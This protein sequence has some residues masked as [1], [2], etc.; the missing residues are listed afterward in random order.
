MAG[1]A[2][3]QTTQPSVY[4]TSAGAYNTAVQN[5]AS[6]AAFGQQVQGYMNPYTQNV[7]NNSL[8]DLERSR[9]MTMNNIGAQASAAN[10]FG[11]SRHG[12]MEAET[13]RGFSDTAARTAANLNMQ[14]Y[15]QAQ[16]TA[17]GQN[18]M[19]SQL[20]NQGFGFGEAITNRQQQQGLLQQGLSQALIDAARGQWSG[21]ANAPAQSLQYPLAAIGGVPSGQTQTA[22]RQPGLFDYLT[23]GASMLNPIG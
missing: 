22:S 8:N 13:N 17:L 15:N 19:L 12:I 6:P 3:P 10:A 18:A 20:A 23:L 11:G 4:N 5:T 9:Q 14:G 16:N 1:A 2:N 21:Y 7:V